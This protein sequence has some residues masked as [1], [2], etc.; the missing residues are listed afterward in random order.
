MHHRV[1]TQNSKRPC[2]HL[3]THS[4]FCG[5]HLKVQNFALS[6]AST[7]PSSS[8]PL[9]APPRTAQKSAL[10]RE[11]SRRDL[12]RE[13]VLIEQEMKRLDKQA[14]KRHLIMRRNSIKKRQPPIKD[15]SSST[16]DTTI[17]SDQSSE[18]GGKCSQ[19]CR[20]DRIIHRQLHEI[21]SLRRQ[22]REAVQDNDTKKKDDDKKPPPVPLDLEFCLEEDNAS[23]V[24]G[25]TLERT[26]QLG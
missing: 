12:Q 17:L 15:M 11:S 14:S 24:S 9:I 3:R 1:V 5:A 18:C 4:Y 7:M 23:I 16:M 21:E 13:R 25:V 20:K 26:V 2:H 19:C 8:S 10:M 22:L 6:L